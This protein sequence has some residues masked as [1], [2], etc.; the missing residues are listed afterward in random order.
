MMEIEHHHVKYSSDPK[1]D[2]EI[3][4]VDWCPKFMRPDIK[5]HIRG[6]TA[7][8]HHRCRQCQRICFHLMGKIG[9]RR[10][11]LECGGYDNVPSWYYHT[12]CKHC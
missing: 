5:G 3:P 11:C 10:F 4:T 9:E 12:G 6:G 8:L 1:S 7:L 2:D